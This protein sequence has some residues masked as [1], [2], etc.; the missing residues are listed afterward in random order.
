[1]KIYFYKL[2]SIILFNLF[3]ISGISAQETVVIDNV[4]KRGFRG[5]KSIIDKTSKEVVGHYVYYKEGSYMKVKFFDLELNITSG[6]QLPISGNAEISEAIYNGSDFLFLT[7]QSGRS[8][9]FIISKKGEK[10]SSKTLTYYEKQDMSAFPSSGDDCFYLILPAYDGLHSGY[11]VQKVNN[12]FQIQ[13]EKEFVPDRG[14]TQVEA[15]YSYYDKFIVIQRSTPQLIFSRKAFAEMICYDNG[16]GNV[17]F[18]TALYDDEITAIPSQILIDR[19]QNIIAAGEFFKGNKARNTNSKGVFIKKLSPAGD[20]IA[21]NKQEWKEGIQ[22]QL[23]K[24]KMKIS[25]KNKVYFHSIEETETGGYQLIGET[26][27]TMFTLGE[28]EIGKNDTSIVNAIGTI[29]NRKNYVVALASGRYVGVPIAD[30]APTTITTQDIILFNFDNDCNITEVQKIDKPYTKVFTY[31]PYTYLP[32]LKLSKILADYGFFDFSFC[33]K[34]EYSESQVL[35]YNSLY[36]RKPHIGIVKISPGTQ[37]YVK[38][39][40]FKELTGKKRSGKK[41]QAGSTISSPGK[42]LVYYFVKKGESNTGNYSGEIH[43]FIKDISNE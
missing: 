27:S 2:L 6:I 17:L 28:L 23:R 38:K 24:T 35:V 31:P 13:W 30:K 8:Q 16:D 36:G 29:A 39:I 18:K 22:K 5:V 1:M 14:Y 19:E 12:Q 26:F 32:G 33:N 43:M 37:P 4:H 25:G 21:Y 42:I 20:D 10:L 41:G 7:K 40:D 3:L 34:P 9:G 15:A 11:K